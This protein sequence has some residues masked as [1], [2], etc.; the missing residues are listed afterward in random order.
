VDSSPTYLE[1]GHI[2]WTKMSKIATLFKQIIDLQKLSFNVVPDPILL[3]FF[4]S[5]LYSVDEVKRF[6][7]SRE[8][9]PPT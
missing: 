5:Q 9:E 7:L 2:S 6:E 1:N 8:L 4:S 3:E